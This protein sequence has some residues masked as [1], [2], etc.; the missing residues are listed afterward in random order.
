MSANDPGCIRT[1]AT[2]PLTASD[3][4]TSTFELENRTLSGLVAFSA[5]AMSLTNLSGAY[6]AFWRQ[7]ITS[8]LWMCD[9]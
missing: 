5:A 8:A 4:E 3:G 9:Q 2:P 6:G 7:P 1:K